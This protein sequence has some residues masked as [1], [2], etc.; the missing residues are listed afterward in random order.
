VDFPKIR[1]R[2]LAPLVLLEPSKA[3][4]FGNQNR[5][6]GVQ[7]YPPPPVDQLEDY[8]DYEENDML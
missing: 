5:H 3:I 4:Q 1:Y 6:V 7:P 2:I 8:E